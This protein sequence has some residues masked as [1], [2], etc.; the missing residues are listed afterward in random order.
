MISLT[1]LANRLFSEKS[2][3][4]ICH[5]HPDGDTIG[6]AVALR[7]MLMEKGVKADIYSD[8][9]VPAKYAFLKGAERI[10]SDD[11]DESKYSALAAIDCADISRLGKFADAY[12][13]TS[14]VT[15]SID[16]HI[17]NGYFARK[18]YVVDKAA[19][20]E[21]IYELALTAGAFISPETADALA[22]GIMTDTGNFRHKNVTP[23]TLR[24]TAELVE[25]GADLN[26]IYFNC[27][28]SQSKERAKLFGLTME[29]I[30]YFKDGK[31]A[32]ISI[33]ASNLEASGAKTEDTEGFIDFVMGIKGVEIGI[34]VMETDKNAYKISL[35]SVSADVNAVAKNFGG[36]GHVLASGCKICGE[37]EEV[38]DR[39]TVTA[40]KYIEE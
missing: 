27:F 10:S 12:L 35:R 33:P 32:L 2:V 4:L 19:N 22:T 31:I 17:S 30:R 38:V 36:G 20:A 37:Y 6:S 8:D 28:A 26:K 18:N 1:A 16:H 25:K 23:S 29:K 14:L 9:P 13:R 7:F 21:N 24:V 15:Y 34:A 39:I 5:I 3:A 40:A 11:I